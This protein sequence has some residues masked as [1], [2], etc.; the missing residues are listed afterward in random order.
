MFFRTELTDL[1]GGLLISSTLRSTLE[2]AGIT[3]IEAVPAILRHPVTGARTEG[4]RLINVVGR[5]ACVD[6]ARSTIVPRPGGGSGI[7]ESFEIDET[8]T[9]G[10]RLFRLDDKPTLIV[11]DARLRRQLLDAPLD[12]VRLRAT[13]VYDGF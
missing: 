11:I 2:D 13:S 9:Q 3:N 8:R 4:S 12:G 5:F 1:V 10:A 6:A 7:L